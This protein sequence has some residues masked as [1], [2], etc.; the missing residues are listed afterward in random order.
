MRILVLAIAVALPALPCAGQVQVTDPTD[1]QILAAFLQHVE[2]SAVRCT[3]ERLAQYAR[4]PEDITWQ[5]S[6][7]IRM[8][9]VAYGLTEEPKYLDAFVERMDNL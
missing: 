4:Q 6:K 9:L 2:K 8:A 5:A 1:A 7:Y 3:P